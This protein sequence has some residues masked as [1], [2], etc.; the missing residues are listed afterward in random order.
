LVVALSAPSALFAAGPRARSVGDTQTLAT[1]PSPGFPEGVV[2]RGDRTYVSGPA[3]FGTAG[4]GPSKVFEFRTA[5]GE[6]RR[7]YDIQGED[8]SQEHA[9]SCI[10][11]DGSGRLYALSTQLGVVRINPRTR[12]QEIYAPTIPHLPVCT[13]PPGPCVPGVD[14]SF[15]PGPCTPGVDSESCLIQPTA[16]PPGPCHS[17]TCFPP[18][19]CTGADCAPSAFPPGPCDG[20][21]CTFPPGPCGGEIGEICFPPGPCAPVAADRGALPNDL[22]FDDAGN[23]YITDSFQAT[24]WRVPPGGGVAE[25]WYQDPRLDTSAIPGFALGLNGVRVS[26]DRRALVFSISSG[27]NAGVAILP[28]VDQPTPL[29]LSLFHAYGP[30]DGADGIA[31]GADGRLFVALAFANQ[32]DI[33]TNQ[34]AETVRFPSAAQNLLR[35]VPYSNPANIAFDGRGGIIV[36]N[37][38]IFDPHPARTSAL[39]GAWVADTASPLARPVFAR[40]DDD[41]DDDDDDDDD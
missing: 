40:G 27:P 7:T 36:T 22:A 38:A 28:L 35:T 21:R 4:Q 9:L 5:T 14:C 31:F 37:H 20:G 16:F 29:G 13:F 30:A 12:V 3:T 23:L 39:L 24:I 6:L 8:L 17:A 19:P 34:G 11:T 41:G 2:V 26:P 10:T 32:I 18:G 25:P 15:P 1:V 33:L